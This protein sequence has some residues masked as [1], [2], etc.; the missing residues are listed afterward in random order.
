LTLAALG[1]PFVVY[2]PLTDATTKLGF[3][4]GPVRD[5]LMKHGFGDLPRAWVVPTRDQA[6][7]FARWTAVRRPVLV[8]PNTVAPHIERFAE[9]PLGRSSP[10][11]ERELRILVLGRLDTF[12]KGLDLLLAHLERQPEGLD[13]MTI[14]LAGDGPARDTILARQKRSPAVARIVRL[15]SWTDPVELLRRHDLLLLPSR[16]EGVPLVMLEAMALGVPVVASDL[17]GTRAFLPPECL[18][19]VGDLTRAFQQVSALLDSKTVDR[20]VARNRRLF[21]QGASGAVFS[22]A[23]DALTGCLR[24][25]AGG[26][27]SEDA[28][29]L[30]SVYMPT[31]NRVELLRRAVESA[32][33]QSHRMIELIVVDDA[34]TDGTRAYL[35]EAETL[36][37]RLRVFRNDHPLGAPASRNLAI[38]QAHGEFITGLDDDDRFDARRVERLLSHWRRLERAGGPFSCVFSQDRELRES[39][40]RVSTKRDYVTVDDLAFFNL[41]GNQVMTRTRHLLDVGS[42]DEQMPAW[43]DLDLFIRLL[44]RFGPARLLDEPLYDLDLGFRTD[45]ISVGSKRRILLAYQRLGEKLQS[46]RCRQGLFLQVFGELYDFPF[47]RHDLREFVRLGFRFRTAKRLARILARQAARQAGSAIADVARPSARDPASVRRGISP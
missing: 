34:S 27:E 9:Q 5:F 33:A 21:A 28:D 36:D 17:P 44:E 42:F 32:L 43:Q 25:P 18:F 35:E 19:P 8:L 7:A 22:T 41:I 10:V 39:G 16:F 38:R 11:G 46:D 29:T 1:Q 24:S 23:V 30:V 15:E 20:V 6:V 47:D 31:R 2:V 3:R 45:R 37:P 13:G 4:S 12:Q 40:T 26:T 14:T